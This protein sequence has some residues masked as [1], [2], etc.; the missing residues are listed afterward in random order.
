MPQQELLIDCSF[1]PL[2]FG[3]ACYTAKANRYIF[4]HRKW[5]T[6]SYSHFLEI[7]IDFGGNHTIALEAIIGQFMI[8]NIIL[9][10]SIDAS[11]E[12]TLI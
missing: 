2:S 9:K 1:K 4:R 5:G 11:Y 7:T 6:A 8:K 3:I 12:G 10:L